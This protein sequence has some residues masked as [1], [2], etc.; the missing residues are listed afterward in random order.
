MSNIYFLFLMQIDIS[1]IGLIDDANMTS[2]ISDYG[3]RIATRCFCMEKQRRGGDDIKRLSLF[4]KLPKK[5]KW[6]Q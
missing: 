2:Y 5:K 4:E 1:I 3:D 6:T